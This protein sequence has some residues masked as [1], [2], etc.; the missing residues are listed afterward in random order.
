MR[1]DD[2][3]LLLQRRPFRPFRIHV[4]ETTTYD[5]RHPEQGILTHSTLTVNLPS[6]GNL[7]HPFLGEQEV[8]IALLHITK[9]VL[10][11]RMASSNGN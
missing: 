8:I 2:L 9:I 11:P 10:L 5:I 3:R 6:P 1:P 7:N 4:H